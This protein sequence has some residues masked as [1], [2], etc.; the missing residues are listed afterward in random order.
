MLVIIN[1]TLDRHCAEAAVDNLFDD[2]IASVPGA[3]NHDARAVFAVL[4]L[5]PHS[6]HNTV[7]KPG[8]GRKP[9]EHQRVSEIIA[10]GNRIL[11]QTHPCKIQHRAQNTARQYILYLRRARKSP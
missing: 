11:E 6:P 5:V 9:R 7:R 2:R 1:N 4:R 3:D 8:T 10:S